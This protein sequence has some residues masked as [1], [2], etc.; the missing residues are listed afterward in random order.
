MLPFFVDDRLVLLE[1]ALGPDYLHFPT[2][3]DYWVNCVND[4]KVRR[5]DWMRFIVQKIID[6]KMGWDVIGITEDGSDLIDPFFF[7]W[8]QL[9]EF[10]Y[11]NWSLPK[12][13]D[14]KERTFFVIQRTKTWLK[15]K[16]KEVTATKS[17]GISS[18]RNNNNS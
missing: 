13:K 14:L 9:L 8:I 6:Y 7:E 3:E 11:I 12:L 2:M 5:R 4:F 1:V 10:P 15:N 16:V 18:A 17:I